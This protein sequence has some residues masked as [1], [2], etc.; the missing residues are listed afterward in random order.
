M[1]I[2]HQGYSYDQNCA[3]FSLHDCYSSEPVMSDEGDLRLDED[4]YSGTRVDANKK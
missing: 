1:A 3:I 2:S 4:Q